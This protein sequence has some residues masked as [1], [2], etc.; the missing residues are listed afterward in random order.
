MR[1]IRNSERTRRRILEAASREFAA[2]GYDGTRIVE[3]ARRAGVSKQLVHHHYAGK[4]ALFQAVHALK[5][6]PAA[7]W[8]E[9]LPHDPTDIIAE[10]FR[11]RSRDLDYIRFLTWEAAS[12]RTLAVPAERA[13]QRR[14]ADYRKALRRLQA[15]G[16]LPREMNHRFIQLAILALATYP[17]AF[18]QMTRLVTGYAPAYARFQRGWYRFLRQ[19]GKKLFQPNAAGPRPQ[20]RYESSARTPERRK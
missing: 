9:F 17:M 18:K 19:I 16:Q 14:V 5:F 13:R 6:R 12:A 15:E 8:P 2:R 4:E 20:P 3:V 7:E 1:R 10:R 11:N